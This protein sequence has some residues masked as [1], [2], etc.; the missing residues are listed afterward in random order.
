VCIRD[1]GLEVV[2]SE[3]ARVIPADAIK[4]STRLHVCSFH[5]HREAH[6]GY[7]AYSGTFPNGVLLGD[8]EWAVLR[9]M[10]LPTWSGGGEKSPAWIRYKFGDAVLHFQS[11]RA[12]HVE[13][14]TLM[15]PD[16]RRAEPV[17]SH[18]LVIISV[19]SRVSIL[20]QRE[21]S[22]GFPLTQQEVSEVCAK[23]AAV[24]LPLMAAAAV[25]DRRGYRDIDLD[26]CWEDWQ[27]V[28]LELIAHDQAR[29]MSD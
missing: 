19:P 9:K 20:W 11:D 10:G 18:R 16:I 28:R 14:I 13:M 5:F 12:G 26:S 17:P 8:P 6:E 24:A 29:E 25:E 27:Q 23:S 15:V 7:A 22:K 4:D 21:L 2:F 1:H 3:A